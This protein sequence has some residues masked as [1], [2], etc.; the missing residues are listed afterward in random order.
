MYSIIE[1]N[2]FLRDVKKLNSKY[3]INIF[4][5]DAYKKY[6]SQ[7]ANNEHIQGDHPLQGRMKGLREFHIPGTI[8]G[9]NLVLVYNKD[10]NRVIIEF[11]KV[12][13]HK[14]TLETFKRTNTMRLLIEKERTLN[15]AFG[16]SSELDDFVN[17]ALGRFST[18]YYV[19]LRL[20]TGEVR[21]YNFKD[22][23]SAREFYD[24]IK[25]ESIEDKV[26]YENAEL[27]LNRVEVNLDDSEEESEY[28]AEE[29]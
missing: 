20:D 24:K 14:D 5:L 15:E 22:E 19:K 23:S 12:G 11:L 1:S 13:T 6:K 25:K 2:R 10:E 18:Y 9:D 27:S 8:L 29:E 3:H 28:L 17:Y 4:A 21:R 26:Y 7:L 16:Q